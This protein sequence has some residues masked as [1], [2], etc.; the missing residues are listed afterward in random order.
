MYTGERMFSNNCLVLKSD[1]V[2][3]SRRGAKNDFG[4]YR[5]AVLNYSMFHQQAIEI[6]QKELAPKNES[7]LVKTDHFKLLSS[8]DPSLFLH[9]NLI[10]LIVNN[11]TNNNTQILIER[12]L[13]DQFEKLLVDN[14]GSS[15]KIGNVNMLGVDVDKFTGGFKRYCLDKYPEMKLYIKNEITDY[16]GKPIKIIR[17]QAASKGSLFLKQESLKHVRCPT[18][19]NRDA[20]GEF[21]KD[22]AEKEVYLK[23]KIRILESEIRAKHA[24]ISAA[25]LAQK[26]R[27]R[28]IWR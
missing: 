17:N 7:I 10:D 3:N 2:C 6:N 9:S 13:I 18:L 21:L 27:D 23:N 4:E 22:L 12:F 25:N 28:D 20:R 15:N 14:A 1:N 26:A 8:K 16:E 19:V 24:E 11:P 5:I